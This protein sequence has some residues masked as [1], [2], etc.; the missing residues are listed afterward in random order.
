PL[1]G[2]IVFYRL[3]TG[4]SPCAL[5]L[6]PCRAMSAALGNMSKFYCAHL[7][8]ISRLYSH[9]DTAEI[10]YFL[11]TIFPFLLAIFSF[12]IR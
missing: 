7:H 9:I 10:F 5:L 2:A 4:A 8:D 11:G 3:S 12:P 1:T 6:S